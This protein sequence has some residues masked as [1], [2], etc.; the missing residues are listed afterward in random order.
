LALL[1]YRIAHAQLNLNPMPILF[2]SYI[3][4]ELVI[5]K[6]IIARAIIVDVQF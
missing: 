6:N 4:P 5:E 1:R 2:Q 3:D